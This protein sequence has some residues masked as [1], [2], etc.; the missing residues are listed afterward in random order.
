[1]DTY[2]I[3]RYNITDQ[4]T[5]TNRLI[6]GGLRYQK[7][8]LS[9]AGEI[10]LSSLCLR[11]TVSHIPLSDLPGSFN[12]SD[13]VLNRI[14]NIGARTIQLNELP[15]RSIPDFWAITDEGA[16]VDSLSP[17]PYTSDYSTGLTTYD[18]DFS[19]KPISNGFG[20]TVLSNTL[21]DG[22]YVFVNVANS[23]ISAHAG[24]SEASTPLA[25]AVLPSSVKLNEWHMIHSSVNISQISVEINRMTLLNFSQTSSFF[26][27]FGLGAS[28][29]HSALFANVSLTA[30][31]QQ[32]YSSSL[33]D[34][35]AL[36][37]FL[38]GTNPMPVSVDGSRRDRI[39]YAGDLDM[40]TDTAFASTYGYEYI[41][42]SIELL[43][44]FQLLPGFFVP[45]AKVQQSPRK[46]DIQANV[47]GLIGYSFSLVSAMAHFY[48]QTGDTE[49]LN[50]WAPKAVRLFDWAHSQT[51][52]NYLL[53]ISDP[54]MG[55]DWN[56]YDP[57]LD[58][59]VSKFNMIYAYSLKQWVPFMAHAGLNVSLYE[60]RLH[61]LQ[62]AI[63]QNL[64]SD[65]LQAFHL[66]ESHKD[67]F[68]QEAN[69]LAILSD[70][71]ISGSNYTP[72]TLLSTMARELYVS[73]GALSFSNASAVSG[74]TQKISPYASGYHLKATFHANDSVNAKRLLHSL[75]GPMSDPNNVNYT[76]C[77][78]EV[79]N[80]DGIPGIGSPTS[81]CH[82]WG[83]GPTADLSRYVLGIQPVIPGFQ[84]WRVNPQTLDL[85]WAQ[86]EYPIPQGKISVDWS[87]DSN[88]QLEMT[89]IAPKGTNGTVYLPSPLRKKL[90]KYHASG[91]VSV[92][93][94][95]FIVQG[96]NPFTFNQQV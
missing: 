19:V 52:P 58:G 43:G 55:G 46:Y 15:A 78:W 33:N 6:Q 81:M 35:A 62:D 71:V 11:P 80:V 69:S 68:S 5:Y 86:G 73:A 7:L 20:F 24:S 31:G 82:A 3:N 39:A 45:N 90:D 57:A 67:F 94:S 91:Y 83:S 53:N 64:W 77:T 26:G 30:Y 89:V 40:S 88:D 27:S 79:M 1:M 28:L 32:M 16:F 87:F 37:D 59:V 9:S 8:N 93:N 95:S 76:G 66:S 47:T 12:C 21:G 36:Q 13:P 29:G 4:R 72:S 84:E 61:C 50:R 92:N 44:S 70:T 2:R 56:Y 48:E 49:F 54:S 25:S 74:W 22:I 14:W 65:S 18:V 85:N 41:N 51:L 75:W 42:G 38:L 17:Q 23:S 63:N 60:G 34:A 96:G 10:E